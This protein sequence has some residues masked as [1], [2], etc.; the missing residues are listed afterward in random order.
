MGAYRRPSVEHKAGV[1][2]DESG[3]E[4]IESKKYSSRS[5]NA[6]RFGIE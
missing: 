1:G 2:T 6:G 3:Q 5:D 4:I